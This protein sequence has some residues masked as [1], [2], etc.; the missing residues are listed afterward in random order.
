[1]FLY[2]SRCVM[3]RL[4]ILIFILFMGIS[5]PQIKVGI[6]SVDYP[7][8]YPRAS[9]S[10]DESLIEWWWYETHQPPN[11]FPVHT[12]SRDARKYLQNKQFDNHPFSAGGLMVIQ[13]EHRCN[14][15]IV[16]E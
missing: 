7:L 9:S 10:V 16:E 12:V 3:K 5:I 15:S 4:L 2:N 6:G 13:N 1:L 11:I 14:D 8:D